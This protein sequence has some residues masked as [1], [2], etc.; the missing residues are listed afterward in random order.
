[1]QIKHKHEFSGNFN[2]RHMKWANFLVS[3]SINFLN[4]WMIFVFT[5]VKNLTGDRLKFKINTTILQGI[6]KYL[7]ILQ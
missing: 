4:L 6:Y 2:A 3:E 5:D 7:R 1:M